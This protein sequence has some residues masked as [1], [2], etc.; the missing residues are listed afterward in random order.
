MSEKILALAKGTGRRKS[1]IAQVKLIPGC[2]DFIINGKSAILYLQEN[3]LS[4]LAIQ[5]PLDL[6]SLQK[7]YTTIVKV[8]GGGL[9]SQADA[10]KLGIARALCE[11]EKTYRPSLKMKNFLTR[12]SRVK[13]RRKYGLKKA[14]KAPQFSKR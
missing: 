12:D 11:I 7:N 6:L 14:R 1:S 8:Q 10:I 4:I 5:S 9:V 3:P 2:G 13:E